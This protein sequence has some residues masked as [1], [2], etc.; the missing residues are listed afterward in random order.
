MKYA[1]LMITFLLLCTFLSCKEEIILVSSVKEITIP[2]RSD[3]NQFV[4]YKLQFEVAKD[5]QNIQIEDITFPMLDIKKEKLRFDIMA[6]S[7]NLIITNII[8][9]GTYILNIRPDDELQN[10]MI[11]AKNDEIIISIVRN[12]KAEQIKISSFVEK[13]KRIR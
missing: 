11:T 13:T 6:V 4:Q 3:E 2:G 7:S 1:S 12:N 9:K 5:G 8:E 10:Q